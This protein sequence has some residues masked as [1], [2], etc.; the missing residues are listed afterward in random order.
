MAMALSELTRLGDKIDIQLVQQL[1]MQARGEVIGPVRTY[2][3]SVFDYISDEELEISMPTENGRMVLFQ[4]GVRCMMLF[5]TQRGL[6][7]CRGVVQKRYKKE[8]FFV[9]AIRLTSAPAKFQRREFFRVDCIK[10]FTYVK[11]DETIATKTST[12]AVFYEIQ[13]PEFLGAD[14]QAVALDISGGGI[15]FSASEELPLDSY[16]LITIRLISDRMDRT[17]YLV[18]RIIAME[19]APNARDKFIGRG[20]FMFKDLKDREVIVRYV[21]DE[22]RRMR[23]KEIGS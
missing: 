18:T 6:Y 20:Q 1:E 12:E 3:S 5:Y 21:F 23:R 17:F 11:I 4:V 7:T 22:E 13:K 9:L 19:P 8:N 14:R 15:R 10:D 2:K 16:I